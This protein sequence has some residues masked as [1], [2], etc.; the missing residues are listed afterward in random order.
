MTLR[1][2]QGDNHSDCVEIIRFQRLLL[3]TF[4]PALFH[5]HTAFSVV[6]TLSL[7]KGHQNES[8]IKKS[9]RFYFIKVSLST[10]ATVLFFASWHID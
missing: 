3:Q 4:K 10:A 5:I 1:Q 7:S 6:V 8:D 9:M 2:A